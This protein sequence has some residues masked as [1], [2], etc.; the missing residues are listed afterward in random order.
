MPDPS[1]GARE[2]G[3]TTTAWAIALITGVLLLLLLTSILLAHAAVGARLR[4]ETRFASIWSGLLARCVVAVPNALP[5]V[6]RSQFSMFFRMWNHLQES[7]QDEVTGRLNE[8]ARQVGADDAAIRMLRRGRMRDR[9]MAI[10]A[11]GHLRDGREWKTLVGLL[12]SAETVV[13]FAAAR[14]LMRIDADRAAREVVDRLGRRA[15]WPLVSVAA[16]LTEAGP[17]AISEA[18]AAAA[19]AAPPEQAPRLVRLLE[20]AHAE[21]ANPVVRARLERDND[22]ELLTACLRV[23]SEPDLLDRIRQRAD[24]PR[25]QVRLHAVKALGRLGTIEDEGLLIRMLSDPEWWVRY[26]AA[27][28]LNALPQ[29]AAGRIERLTSTLEDRFARDILRQVVAEKALAC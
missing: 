13:S 11:L 21:V 9:L 25:W 6:R 26:R 3:F 16:M 28:A 23:V 20:F 7:L 17:D 5:A 8:L 22:L 10:T 4:R 2:I 19:R 14:A 15:D 12:D 18:L 29:I 27:Q 1:F 24:D